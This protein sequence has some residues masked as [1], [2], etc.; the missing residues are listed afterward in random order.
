ME[1]GEI[2]VYHV[3]ECTF[4]GT[5]DRVIHHITD[6]DDEQHTWESLG[7]LH[8]GEFRESYEGRSPQADIKQ[9]RI[10]LLR[11]AL[12]V[13]TVVKSPTTR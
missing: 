11:R 9:R 2:I 12:D 7:Y 4:E 10:R 8:S 1:R 5:L 3:S 13:K 6:Q